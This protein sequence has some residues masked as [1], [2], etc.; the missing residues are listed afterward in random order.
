MRRLVNHGQSKLLA[1]EIKA[2][3]WRVLN[4]QQVIDFRTTVLVQELQQ[5]LTDPISLLLAGG[6]GFI[7]GELTKC[8]PAKF[9]GNI[10]KA[11]RATE[12]SPLRTA[13]NLMTS[14]RTLYT[15]LPLAWI[16]KS[17]YQPGSSSH[18]ARQKTHPVPASRVTRNRRRYNRRKPLSS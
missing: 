13:I 14:A 6:I 12:T 15:A 4:R 9:R 8:Q 11:R 2:A 18:A 16:V 10:D 7:L 17:R 1:D 3:E 5:Q